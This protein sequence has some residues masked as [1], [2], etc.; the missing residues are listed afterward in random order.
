MMIQHCEFTELKLEAVLTIDS[1][2]NDEF[3]LKIR[4][5]IDKPL[6]SQFHWVNM[7][8]HL[9]QQKDHHVFH[10]HSWAFSQGKYQNY[11]L[12]CCRILEKS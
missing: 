4:F 12:H 2:F 11:L 7:E 1:K 8:Y 3:C 5:F 9:I 10:I 6:S